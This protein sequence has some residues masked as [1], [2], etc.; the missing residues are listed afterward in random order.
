MSGGNA[1]ISGTE[2]GGIPLSPL[3]PNIPPPL[4]LIP[5]IPL[6]PVIPVIPPLPTTLES[7]AR[8]EPIPPVD[9]N[10]GMGGAASIDSSG[11]GW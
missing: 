4:P 5:L 2:I 11:G 3:S 10:R 1:P 8:D 7:I 6:I 9:V